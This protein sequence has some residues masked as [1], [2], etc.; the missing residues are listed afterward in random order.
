MWC[1]GE[2]FQR[3]ARRSSDPT[4]VG[5]QSIDKYLERIYLEFMTSWRATL[6]STVAALVLFGCG[7]RTTTREGPEGT[8]S[9][10]T[11]TDLFLN[12]DEAV[13]QEGQD[14]E[15][16]GRFSV[17]EEKFLSVYRNSD[18][19]PDRRAK[20]LIEL[21]ELYSNALNPNRDEATALTYFERVADEFPGAEQKTRDAAEKAAADLRG[22]SPSDTSGP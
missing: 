12:R 7:G 6:A 15:L 2:R 22:T 10:Q 5:C 1:V 18:A 11:S 3:I 21:G 19:K 13:L 9:Y 4:E 20:A 17:A 8:E 16:Q 14:A